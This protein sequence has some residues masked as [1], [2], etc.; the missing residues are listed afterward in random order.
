MDSITD[1][2]EVMSMQML[3]ELFPGLDPD[4]VVRPSGAVDVM[5]GLNYAGF[6]LV[7]SAE[8]SSK[9]LGKEIGHLRVLESQF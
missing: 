7:P 2:L 9:A 4:K 3:A 1:R 8:Y 6:H 5:I